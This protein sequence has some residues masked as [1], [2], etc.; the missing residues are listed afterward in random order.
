MG[1]GKP[2]AEGGPVV[3]SIVDDHANLCYG[4]L[5]R[6]PQENSSFAAG[7][8]AATVGEFLALDAAETRRSDVVLLDL[9]LRDG[10]APAQK[11]YPGWSEGIWS[12]GIW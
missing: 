5:G 1:R 3:F 7:V 12:G 8:M 6:L 10:S 4:V 9:R 11:R 2:P